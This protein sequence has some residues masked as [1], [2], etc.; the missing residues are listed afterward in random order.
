MP[1]A[2][3]IWDLLIGIKKEYDKAEECFKNVLN[4]KSEYKKIRRKSIL[5]LGVKYNRLKIS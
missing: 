3:I 4:I 5:N 1:R 2:G